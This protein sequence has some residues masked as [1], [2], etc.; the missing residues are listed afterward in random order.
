MS[1]QVSPHAVGDPARDPPP[2]PRRA[3]PR[4]VRDVAHVRGLDEDRRH[5]REA[6][7]TEVGAG[8]EPVPAEV[9]GARQAGALLVGAP[10]R[11]PQAER[12]VVDVVGQ[13]FDPRR[14]D[15]VEPAA[16][17]RAA[18]GVDRDHRVGVRAVADPRA[19]VDARADAAVGA[20][21]Q[22][23]LGALTA[24]DAR[25]RARHVQGEARLRVAAGRSRPRRV[26]RL[27]PAAPD[28]HLAVD[29]LGVGGVAA[30]VP[31]VEHDRAPGQIARGGGGQQRE[32]DGQRPHRGE[33]SPA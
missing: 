26:A 27:V 9:G 13:P 2:E 32:H 4:G 28:R 7:A 19:P 14:A 16:S 3:H 25:G 20:P 15:D 18:V 30:V 12:L 29:D 11:A 23:H 21:G 1:Q 22:H 17:S 5:V 33:A 24:E 8:D 6:Q 31:R 10:Q